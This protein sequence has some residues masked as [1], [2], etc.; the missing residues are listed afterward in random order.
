MEGAD[1]RVLQDKVL[2]NIRYKDSDV[3]VQKDYSILGLARGRAGSIS[4]TTI[5]NLPKHHI[6]VVY[7]AIGRYT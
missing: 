4:T 3:S 5:T 7:C 2:T 6:S 1:A